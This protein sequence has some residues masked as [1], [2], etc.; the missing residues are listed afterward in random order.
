VEVSRTWNGAL[1]AAIWR[2]NS[3]PSKPQPSSTS[4]VASSRCSSW[5]AQVISSSAVDP[6]TVPSSARVS[7]LGLGDLHALP[8]PHLDQ[9]RFELG[10]H[11]QDV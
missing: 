7:A 4:M 1:V 10:D 8:G 2:K 11:G 6:K 3:P 5:N 9:V